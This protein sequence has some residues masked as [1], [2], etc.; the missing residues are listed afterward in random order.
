M[1]LT[2]PPHRILTTCTGVK[3]ELHHD[4]KQPQNTLGWP[5]HPRHL[6]TLPTT[7]ASK[8]AIWQILA[9]CMTS[10]PFVWS[11]HLELVLAESRPAVKRLPCSCN[12]AKRLVW[13]SVLRETTHHRKDRADFNFSILCSYPPVG[14]PAGRAPCAQACL[15]SP[16]SRTPRWPLESALV[17]TAHNAWPTASMSG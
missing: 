7:C 11:R 9:S 10:H 16:Q 1:T 6:V 2:V 3:F 4:P 14:P 15:K 8:G 13:R 5:N 17:W 12:L